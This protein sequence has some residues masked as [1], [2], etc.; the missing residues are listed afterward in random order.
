MKIFWI[1]GIFHVFTLKPATI[2]NYN[3][4]QNKTKKTLKVISV[5][6]KWCH[7]MVDSSQVGGWFLG[8]LE[9]LSMIL[10]HSEH[11]GSPSDWLPV[12]KD[13]FSPFEV[14]DYIFVAIEWSQGSHLPFY[15]GADTHT[16]RQTADR[17]RGRQVN[18]QIDKQANKQTQTDDE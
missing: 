6:L 15:L 18:R 17:W 4:L 3:I 7:L 9:C 5:C 2:T 14:L 10:N 1:R 16:V 13:F 8:L 11:F 12:V